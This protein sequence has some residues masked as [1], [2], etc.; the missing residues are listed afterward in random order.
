M[1]R[2]TSLTPGPGWNRPEFEARS[3]AEGLAGFGTE[4]TPGT[5][6]G[7]RWHANDIW[8][9][10]TFLL[11]TSPPTH[12]RLRVYQTEDAEIYL[13]GE[14]ALRLDR[15]ATAYRYYPLSPEA[16]KSLRHGENLLAVHSRHTTGAQYIDVGLHDL[17]NTIDDDHPILFPGVCEVKYSDGRTA[18]LV[19]YSRSRKARTKQGHLG[20]DAQGDVTQPTWERHDREANR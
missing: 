19:Q 5:F 7:T 11:K 6:V 2:Y 15:H 10:R 14:L 9:R 4:R 13:N 1:W 3:W 8:L 12:P 20:Q 18:V 16:R 17:Q